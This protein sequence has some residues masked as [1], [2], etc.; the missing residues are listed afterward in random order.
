MR[1]LGAE[2]RAARSAFCSTCRGRNCA[3]A[4]S[5][6]GAVSTRQGRSASRSTT[7]RRRAT[8]RASTCRIRRSCGRCKPGHTVLI[9]DGKVRLHVVEC[10]A[11]PRRR[12]RRRRRHH[13]EPQGRQPARHRDPRLGDDAKDR[14]DLD[15]GA[16]RRRRLGRRLLRAAARGRRRGQED[17]RAGARSCMSKIEKPQAI[18]QLDEIIEISDGSDGRARR[19]RRRNAAREGAGPA[20]AHHAVCAAPR[21]ARR[22]RDADARIDDHLAGADPRRSLGRRDRRVRGRRRGHAVGRKRRR[23]IS[24]RS[25]RDDEPH[26]RRGRARSDLSARIIN[27]Q[28]ADPEATGADAI[29]IAARDVAETL[30]LKAIVAWTSSGST[31]L[32]IARERPWAADP[33][34]DAQSDRPRGRLALVWGVHAVVTKDAQ[35][36]DDMATRAGKFAIREGFADDRRP[37]HHRSPACRSARRARP[38]WCG[39]ISSMRRRRC[40]RAYPPRR[41]SRRS[42]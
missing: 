9:D 39:S 36:I 10:D 3:S 32:R 31:A 41:N 15:A 21:Q 24:D 12:D 22:R 8:R 37:H 1:P 6:D 4:R 34:A 26:R 29:A 25:R 35:D 20:E 28:R 13:L 40:R 18:A 19:P 30:D 11:T 5:T 7:T 27:A 17:R 2:D 23:P 33:R 38:I 14:A 42:S 16:R